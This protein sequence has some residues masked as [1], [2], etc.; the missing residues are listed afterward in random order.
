MIWFANSFFCTMMYAFEALE[1]YLAAISKDYAL[2][3]WLPLTSRVGGR[4]L[5]PCDVSW[6][7]AY[8][9]TLCKVVAWTGATCGCVIIV[10]CFLCAIFADIQP[11]PEKLHGIMDGLLRQQALETSVSPSDALRML[12]AATVTGETLVTEVGQRIPFVV[13]TAPAAQL[14]AAFIAMDLHRQ[15]DSN[16]DS[17]PAAACITGV[18]GVGKSR[19]ATS[20][21]VAAALQRARAEQAVSATAATAPAAAP[22]SAAAAP[23]SSAGQELTV[24]MLAI[25]L[26]KLLVKEGRL[27]VQSG[28]EEFAEE[29]CK[30]IMLVSAACCYRK[31]RY[32]TLRPCRRIWRVGMPSS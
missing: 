15:R 30:Q 10:Y 11:K 8:F 20:A 25:S 13:H 14:A 1:C 16:E 2:L 32:D 27:D 31:R 7:A 23:S 21:I 24:E 18:P 28:E 26:R 12:A 6:Y 9:V 3:S 19:T 29:R 5:L 4:L 17:K 22:A